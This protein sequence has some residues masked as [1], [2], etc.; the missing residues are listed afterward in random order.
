MH[1]NYPTYTTSNGRPIRAYVATAIGRLYS[2]DGGYNN[3]QG[4]NGQI[5][6]YAT[7]EEAIRAATAEKTET[8]DVDVVNTR[9]EDEPEVIFHLY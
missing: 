3:F 6:E 7:A 9:A 8:C 5:G 2:V 1:S 4:K